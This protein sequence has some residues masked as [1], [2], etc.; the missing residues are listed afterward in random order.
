M[1]FCMHT[2]SI[3]FWQKG[4]F[5]CYHLWW[6]GASSRSVSL[7]SDLRSHF[8]Y[9]S[10]NLSDHVISE[11]SS[12]FWVIIWYLSD[13]L[14]FEWSSSDICVIILYLISG[15]WVII[16]ILSDHVVF[17]WSSDFLFWLIIWI[18][19]LEPALHSK[20]SLSHCV[21]TRWSLKH[22]DWLNRINY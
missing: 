2:T 13:Y 1:I 8:E 12:D 9:S 11:W 20:S 15:I 16:W 19:G 22:L 5:P 3:I 14:K 21:K 18:R 6:S 17:E 7:S 4:K 10:S